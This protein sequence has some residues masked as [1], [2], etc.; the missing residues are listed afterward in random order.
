VVSDGIDR[1]IEHILEREGVQVD[2]VW[3]NRM[4]EDKSGKFTLEF[5]NA[6]A[7]CSLGICK[8]A[9]L[10]KAGTA[11]TRVVIGDSKSDFCWAKVADILFAK[12]KLIDYCRNEGLAH[13]EFENFQSVQKVLEERLVLASP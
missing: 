2:C 10:E 9:L 11:I 1:I 3:S 13:I 12:K 7:D 8:C 4:V 6:S 5:P